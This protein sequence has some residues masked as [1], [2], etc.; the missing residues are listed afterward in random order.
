M[1]TPSTP[2]YHGKNFVEVVSS[3][4]EDVVSFPAIDIESRRKLTRVPILGREA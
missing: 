3:P 2:T 1:V 4:K